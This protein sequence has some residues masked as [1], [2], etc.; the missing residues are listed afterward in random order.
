[1]ILPS[2]I[3]AAQICAQLGVRHAVLSPGSRCAALSIAFVRHP[4]IKTYT[5]SDERSA[6][7]VA[8]GIA[9]QLHEPVVLIC[10]SGS[11]AY[12]Y[13]PAVAE[14]FFQQ[15]SLLLLTADRPPEWID[16]L[17]GQTIRQREIYGRH[18]KASFEFPIGQTQED[19]WYASRMVSEAHNLCIAYPQGPV[20]INVPIR[21]PFYPQRGEEIKFDQ[22]VKVIR[23]IPAN[24][25]LPNAQASTLLEQWNAAE[26][27]LIVCGQGAMEVDLIKVIEK[28]SKEH[29]IPVI[30]DVISNM[31]ALSGAVKHADVLLAQKD[32]DLLKQ[33]Q[34]D[35]LITFGLSVMSKNLKLFLRKYRPAQHWHI[36]PSGSAADTFQALTQVVHASPLAFFQNMLQQKGILSTQSDLVKVWQ[37]E[38][39]K[40]ANYINTLFEKEEPNQPGEFQAVKEVLHYLP[41]QSN[42]HLANSMAVRYANLVGLGEKQDGVEVFAN[43][44][45]SGIDGSNSTAV[46]SALSSDRLTVLITGDLAFFYDRNAFWHNYK[47]PNL[48]VILLNNHAGGIFRMIDGPASQPELEEYFETRQTLEAENTTRDFGMQYQH[49][50]LKS[51]ADMHELKELL[52]GFYQRSSAHTQLLEIVTDARVNT[53]IFKQYKKLIQQKYGA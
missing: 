27:K 52:P 9:R 35:L 19:Q 3:Q 10:T 20:H 18:I 50:E 48:R 11:A 47:L 38:E 31:H 2:I 32:E 5:L 51:E 28:I 46:G 6:A 16:Q 12:N 7:F 41:D 53:E 14:A 4:Q 21:E 39:Q 37:R 36:Q 42:L 23:Q 40:A 24:Y 45:T 29:Q 49:I 25:S 17:D 15:I 1:M 44:G 26:K 13:A 30:A 34:P 33:L 22:D 8:L 43:R